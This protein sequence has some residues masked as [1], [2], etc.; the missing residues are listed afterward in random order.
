LHLAWIF[1]QSYPLILTAS[2][3]KRRIFD[4]SR[5]SQRPP[6]C[7][8]MRSASW[9]LSFEKRWFICYGFMKWTNPRSRSLQGVD[10]GRC[11][12]PVFRLAGAPLAA[13]HFN[14]WGESANG[15]FAIG[16]WNESHWSHSNDHI[17]FCMWS[18]LSNLMTKSISV[19]EMP[20]RISNS[21]ATIARNW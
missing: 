16:A 20:F 17:I 15:H 21:R 18:C 7:A 3:D 12:Q 2:P 19:M 4:I 10:T 5:G 8:E 9:S 1:G 13:S 14:F 6:F 11:F